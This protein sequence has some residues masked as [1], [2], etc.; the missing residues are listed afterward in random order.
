[1]DNRRGPRLFGALLLIAILLIIGIFVSKLDT[2]ALMGIKP[3]TKGM[4]ETRTWLRAQKLSR[5]LTPEAV[6]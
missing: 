5:S 6:R 1:M 4:L 2:N 3:Y